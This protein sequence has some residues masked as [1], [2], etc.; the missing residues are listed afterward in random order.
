MA[1]TAAGV[2]GQ[3]LPGSPERP[4][5]PGG[6]AASGRPG[7]LGSSREARRGV[8]AG[9]VKSP[10]VNGRKERAVVDVLM[11]LQQGGRSPMNAAERKVRASALS[12]GAT[13]VAPQTGPEI[14]T[15]APR[16]SRTEI[17]MYRR[18]AQR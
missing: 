10:V 9:S 3:A 6:I 16:P 17:G 7:V 15:P 18:R 11:M 12:E 1:V 14:P 5:I 2:G 13:R 8:N 4:V